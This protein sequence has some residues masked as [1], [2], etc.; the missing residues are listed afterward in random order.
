MNR[1]QYVANEPVAAI[2]PDGRKAA[3]VTWRGDIERN[4]NV[5]S[6]QVFNLDERRST[7]PVVLLSRD[8]VGDSIDQLATP[9]SQ[10]TFLSDSRTLAFVGRPQGGPAQVFTV[11]TVNAEVRQ[12]TQHDAAVRSFVIGADRK[13][14]AFSAAV[15]SGAATELLRANEE[16]IVATDR[17]QFPFPYQSPF[18]FV[19]DGYG[20]RSTREYFVVDSAESPRKIFDSRQSRPAVPL[21]VNDPDVANNLTLSLEDESALSGWATLTGNAQG[22]QTLLFPYG[23]TDHP[24]NPERYD[25]YR[26]PRMNAYARRVAAPYGLVDL[27]TGRIERLI[28]APHPQFEV[29]ESGS[30]LWAPDGRSVILY[31]LLPDVPGASPQWVEVDIATRAITPLHLPRDVRPV[32]W[33]NAGRALVLSGKG[34]RFFRVARSADGGWGRAMFAGALQG[35]NGF[36]TEATDGRVV[37]GVKDASTRAPELASYELKSG[38]TR[39]LSD[40]NPQLRE[41]SYGA[42]ERFQWNSGPQ[43]QGTGFLI[44]PLNFEAGKRYPLVILLDDGLLG[45][46]GDPYLLDAAWQLSGHAIQMLAA[47]GFMVLYP[48]GPRVLAGDTRSE[49]ERERAHIEAAVATLYARGLID[50]RRIGISGWSRAGYLTDYLLI[51][52]SIAFAAATTIDG[53]GREYNE[54]MRPYTDAELLRIR[55][56]TLFEAHGRSSLVTFG[57]MAD[58]ML[59]LGRAAELLYFPTA[60]HSTTRPRHRV[61]SLGLHID[62]WRFWLKGE[63]DSDLEKNA[64]YVRWR[65]LRE[66]RG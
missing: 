8:F 54:G 14:L 62:W 53:G 50:A 65:K 45:Q 61:R 13:L 34:G 26:S 39:V 52:S 46:E 44:K 42:V 16:G 15:P 47:N 21:D 56:P 66:Q 41:R 35:F 30:P 10:L 33:V 18:A 6:L 11:D 57:G 59:A 19:S 7:P 55:A 5:Y 32:A 38:R 27:K 24:M 23:L 64:Q 40:L 31:T 22:T 37:I 28:D 58:R 9:I 51:H 63:E 3:T 1:I 43:Q 4:V 25:Y 36:W 49:G 20:Q 17:V 48:H 12:L 60:S 2:S 29:H